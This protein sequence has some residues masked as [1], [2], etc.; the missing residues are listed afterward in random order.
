MD[1]DHTKG[2]GQMGNAWFT[3]T[4]PG[5]NEFVG[6][7]EG[8]PCILTSPNFSVIG[9]SIL[10]FWYFFGAVPFCS[11]TSFVIDMSFDDGVTWMVELVRFQAVVMDGAWTFVKTNLPSG[12]MNVRVRM[13]VTDGDSCALEAG[14]DDFLI[15]PI[16]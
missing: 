4:N 1:G 7:V 14:I 9:D 16:G 8:G 15:C 2:P 5:G 10:S 13:R 12:T 3:G 11:R 6:D